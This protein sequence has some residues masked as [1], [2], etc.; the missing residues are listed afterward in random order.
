[1]HHRRPIHPVLWLAVALTPLAA[2][3]EDE[4]EIA[5]EVLAAG[6][7]TDGFGPEVVAPAAFAAA[8]DGVVV[9]AGPHPVEVVAT[10]DGNVEAYLVGPSAP[11]PSDV[12]MSVRVP[13]DQGPRPVMLTWDPER[14][15]YRG[16]VREVAIAPG[17]VTVRVVHA[18]QTYRG[19]APQIVILAPESPTL[20]VEN[21]APRPATVVVERPAPPPTTVVVERPARPGAVVV[22]DH[23]RPRGP[24]VVVEH[25]RPVVVV[26]HPRPARVRVVNGRRGHHDR[27]RHLGHRRH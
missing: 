19:N 13:T 5:P 25:P 1:M 15:A 7:P 11:P 21:E 23:P 27:G 22:V 6:E 9:Q 18:G 3:G 20:V 17:P 8:H 24:V 12:T 26:E 2:C 10:P 4:E 14:A 16:T